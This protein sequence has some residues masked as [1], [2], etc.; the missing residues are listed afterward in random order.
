MEVNR[1]LS[2]LLPIAW[3]CLATPSHGATMSAASC[4]Q[5]AVQTAVNAAANGDRVFVPGGTCTWSARVSWSG[6]GITLEG[7]GVDAT[8]ITV[9]TT[10]TV[11]NFQSSGSYALNRV[12]GFTFNANNT[13]T[14]SNNAIVVNDVVKGLNA[15][16]IDHNKF[17][18]L[19]NRAI[20]IY[21]AGHDV[22]GVIDHNTFLAPGDSA[23]QSIT[24]DGGAHDLTIGVPP[25]ANAQFGYG[26][27]PGT[28]HGIFVEDNTFTYA[29]SA[30]DATVEGY[31]G[32]RYI[33]RHNISSGTYAVATHH[34]TDT[35]GS[36]S[37]HGERGM[38]GLEIYDNTATTTHNVSARAVWRGGTGLVWGNTTTTSGGGS[39]SGGMRFR[40]AR[41]CTAYPP[42][43]ICN[44][45]S[46]WDGNTSGQ[47]GYPCLDQPGHF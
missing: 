16:R 24:I 4:S 31:L 17:T 40:N 23:V 15:F 45:T 10:D 43:G 25:S 2:L 39:Y 8:I 32:A 7:A 27:I 26:Y 28:N 18:N 11:L 21:M 6:K 9:N 33:F 14:S 29:I 47:Q 22:S 19:A 35:G 36:G 30:N 42:F 1:R 46:P 38:S 34:G 5:S 12:T 3:L 44:G 20:W 41:S 37:T 13:E